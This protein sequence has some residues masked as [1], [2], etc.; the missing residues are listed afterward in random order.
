[1]FRSLGWVEPEQIGVHRSWVP[2]SY[3]H[4]DVYKRQGYKRTALEPG[5][6]IRSIVLKKH[7]D[8][9][10][11]YGRKTG[12]RNAQAISKVCIAGVGRLR[13]GLSLIHI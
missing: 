5:E 11:S 6:L 7:F 1:M 8:G 4:L 13:Q 10:F 2:V 3:T 9:Y 12:A